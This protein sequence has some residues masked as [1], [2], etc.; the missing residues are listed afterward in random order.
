M[1]GNPALSSAA[2]PKLLRGGAISL[3]WQ[4]RPWRASMCRATCDGQS[5]DSRGRDFGCLEAVATRGRAFCIFLAP[6]PLPDDRSPT[7]ARSAPAPSRRPR[8][9]RP[10]PRRVG[11]QKAADD[12]ASARQRSTCE[13]RRYS[14]APRRRG[15]AMFTPSCRTDI[16]RSRG[17]PRRPCH[18]GHMATTDQNPRRKAKS[19]RSKLPLSI[20]SSGAWRACARPLRRRRHAQRVA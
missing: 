12:A 9:C 13:R 18:H 3:R 8:R 16:T 20:G 6:S 11:E 19:G 14:N 1:S 5:E 10:G 17:V 15:R 7:N 2:K 4:D